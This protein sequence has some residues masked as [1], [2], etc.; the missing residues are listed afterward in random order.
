LRY[1]P[2]TVWRDH[3]YYTAILIL[4]VA[5]TI[6]VL[7]EIFELFMDTNFGTFAIGPRFDTNLDLLMNFLGSSLFL[8][9]QL[10]LH[11][12]RKAKVSKLS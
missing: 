7:N 6:G 5:Q 9:V 1:L 11:E 2:H 8:C 12:A 4:S 3:P 10:I